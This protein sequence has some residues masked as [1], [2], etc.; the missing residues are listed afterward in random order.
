MNYVNNYDIV[1][2]LSSLVKSGC[3]KTAAAQINQL[4]L[5]SP[6][7]KSSALIE[8]RKYLISASTYCQDPNSA[9]PGRTYEDILASSNKIQEYSDLITTCKSELD[10]SGSQGSDNIET[11]SGSLKYTGSG[12]DI[13]SFSVTS[14]GGFIVSGTNSGNSNFIVHIT[15]TSGSVEDFV[16]NEIGPYSGKKIIRIGAGKHYL[17]VNAEGSWTI[18]ITPA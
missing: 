6:M 12:D 11:S 3:D 4:L 1:S 7:P 9:A 13:R 18:I 17:D 16:F 15:D 8:V 14:G 10:N 5:K 2:R